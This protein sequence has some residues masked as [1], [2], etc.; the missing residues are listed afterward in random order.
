[1]PYTDAV[2]RVAQIQSQLAALQTAFYASGH[3]VGDE[4]HVADDEHATSTTGGSSFA[5]A[6]AQAGGH[7]GDAATGRRR[8]RRR[9]RAC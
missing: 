7:D 2:T 1:M 5:N 9:P 8:C 6:L 3:H 4:Q